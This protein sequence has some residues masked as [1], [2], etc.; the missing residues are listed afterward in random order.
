VKTN[1]NSK[2]IFLHQAIESALFPTRVKIFVPKATTLV[3]CQ[4]QKYLHVITYEWMA[5][6][7]ELGPDK[8]CC[9]TG[10]RDF[11]PESGISLL[12]GLLVNRNNI[13]T[14]N[15]NNL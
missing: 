7:E 11:C 9:P 2:L 8:L 12:P 13:Y 4:P 15:L 1:G 6:M 10:V 5:E 3:I 14:P